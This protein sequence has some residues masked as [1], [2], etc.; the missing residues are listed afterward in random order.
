MAQIH[1]CLLE[2][3]LIR[4]P[5]S[6]TN[7]VVYE[8][9]D[10]SSAYSPTASTSYNNTSSQ[11]I[12]SPN[13][14]ELYIR[15]PLPP[16]P[17]SISSGIP[18]STKKTK[19]PK[20]KHFDK[21]RLQLTSSVGYEH[22]KQEIDPASNATDYF[23]NYVLDR[24]ERPAMGSDYIPRSMCS[25][26]NEVKNSKDRSYSRARKSNRDRNSDKFAKK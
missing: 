12:A 13:N 4:H 20:G 8:D 21:Q 16:L 22:M 7:S 23:E 15:R 5:R 24:D 18:P 19:Y 10:L 14:V 6:A 25:R 2:W 26:Q 1:Q 9:W 17:S 11:L 3:N